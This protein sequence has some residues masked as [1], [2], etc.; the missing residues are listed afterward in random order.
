MSPATPEHH[1]PDFFEGT[2]KRIEIDFAS[3][4]E[5][6]RG[7]LDVDSSEWREVARTAGTQ[8]LSQKRTAEFDSYLLSES[9]LLVYPT[10]VILKTCGRTDPLA[11]IPRITSL[12]KCVGLEPE[13]SCYSRK[14][15]LAPKRQPEAY[16]NHLSEIEAC[17]GVCATGDAYILGAVTGDHWFMYNSSYIY[18][19]SS[20]RKDFTVDIMMY[21]LHEDVRR[22]FYTE[23]QEGS[24]KGAEQM[25]INSGLADVFR[26]LGMVDDYCFSP[27]GYSANVH[28][29]DAYCITHVTPEEQCSFASF[30]TNFGRALP[31]EECAQALNELSKKVL[32]I[33]RPSKFTMTLFYDL[34]A[35]S[36]LG[37]APFE[38]AA[39]NF[40]RKNVNTY[41]F[42]ED[43]IATVA[44]Y[45]SVQAD[46]PPRPA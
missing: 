26:E 21:E 24:Q 40:I 6:D 14:N 22:A 8:V 9:S 32:R 27:C 33:F 13:W 17:E 16:Q 43:Y 1:T 41:H 31:A 35:A 11:C 46:D 45:V 34:G 23:E 37:N 10:K 42:E 29:G 18:V 20:K 30:E 28:V 5:V 12:A 39:G 4:Q 25:R 38:S 15:F 36:A 19:D 3:V 2:E 44:N 7:C